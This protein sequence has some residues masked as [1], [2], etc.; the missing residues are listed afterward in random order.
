MLDEEE[1]KREAR[2]VAM[3]YMLAELYGMVYAL[4]R[5]TPEVIQSSLEDFQANLAEETIEGSDPVKGDLAIGV[6][7]D[8]FAALIER[9]RVS[10]SHRGLVTPKK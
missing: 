6:L 1:L 2:L 10:A 3:E 7:E 9:I 4:A 8:A 5:A